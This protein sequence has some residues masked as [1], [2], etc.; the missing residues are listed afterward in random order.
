MATV[1]FSPLDIDLGLLARGE[2]DA[3][4]DRFRIWYLPKV[5]GQDDSTLFYITIRKLDHQSDVLVYV[6]IVPDTETAYEDAEGRPSFTAGILS[7]DDVRA[8]STLSMILDCPPIF[9]RRTELRLI[10]RKWRTDPS[11]VARF[12]ANVHSTATAVLRESGPTVSMRLKLPP[13]ALAELKH[14]LDT[15]WEPTRDVSSAET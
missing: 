2:W 1:P 11:A 9:H 13:E 5:N 7:N 8:R 15:W 6:H 4:S 12:T 14:H 3:L 10:E